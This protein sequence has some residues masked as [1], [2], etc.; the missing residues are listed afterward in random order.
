MKAGA[1][2]APEDLLEVVTIV[3][4]F[5]T[6]SV[7]KLRDRTGPIESEKDHLS[8]CEMYCLKILAQATYWGLTTLTSVG[9]GDVTPQTT[10][11]AG[12]VRGHGGETHAH[13]EYIFVRQ[14]V[15]VCV[16]VRVYVCA[17]VRL[18]MCA[19]VLLSFSIYIMCAARRQCHP[20][21]W[22]AT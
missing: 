22:C 18:C 11:A 2:L 5:L 21:L 12:V 15:S 4:E 19:C 10:G 20:R 13:G 8:S 17:C 6:N 9:S 3:S 16:C 14:C 7:S 1:R